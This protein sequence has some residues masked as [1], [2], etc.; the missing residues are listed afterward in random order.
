[1]EGTQR[2]RERTREGPRN[3]QGRTKKRPLGDHSGT[4]EGT[5]RD[6]EETREGQQT[7][8]NRADVGGGVPSA[9]ARH[10]VLW[11]MPL[12]AKDGPRRPKTAQDAPN[13]AARSPKMLPIWFHDGPGSPQYGPKKAPR[14]P[15]KPPRRP[16]W[17]PR[18]L[19]PTQDGLKKA[20]KI[21]KM[22]S[23]MASKITYSHQDGP[24]RSN[25]PPSSPKKPPGRIQISPKRPKTAQGTPRKPGQASGKPEL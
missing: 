25:M 22:A 14:R 20:C 5:Q 19:L 21:T 1:M 10:W 7:E 11:S 8:H 9:A 12:L 13:I 6:L 4:M 3:D 24:R 15:K 2:D 23:K 17:P 16:R 18:P